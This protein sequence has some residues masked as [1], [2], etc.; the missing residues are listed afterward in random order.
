M[1]LDQPLSIDPDKVQMEI[2]AL[3]DAPSDMPSTSTLD[4]QKAID[5]LFKT[6]PAEG[7]RP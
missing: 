5:D 1:M 2:P 3:G 4:A 7:A 6:P